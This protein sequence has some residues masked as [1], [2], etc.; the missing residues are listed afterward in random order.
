MM[1]TPRG[2]IATRKAWLHFGLDVPKSSAVEQ[3]LFD[4]DENEDR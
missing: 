1:R 3:D 4:G 2:R